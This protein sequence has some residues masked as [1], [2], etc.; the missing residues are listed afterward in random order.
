MAI[1]LLGLGSNIHPEQHLAEAIKELATL[2]DVL[3]A[4]PRVDTSPVGST[5]SN[6]F[7]NQLV[8]MD[9]ELPPTLLKQKLLR[10]ESRHG[11]EA[12]CPERKNRDRTL[13]I[14]I[15][16]LGNS[17]EE[18]LATPL[19]DSYYQEVMTYWQTQQSACAN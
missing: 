18:C 6:A 3:S 9:S 19:E 11:R 4:S 13:D 7:Q 15:L 8:L 12:K 2:G 16:T 5:F 10:I 17:F 14:D 1:Y